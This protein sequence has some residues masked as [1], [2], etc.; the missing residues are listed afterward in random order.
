M[1]KQLE[2]EPIQPTAD[3]A[4][5]NRKAD[6]D[7]GGDSAAEDDV[8]TKKRLRATRVLADR[9]PCLYAHW[10]DVRRA[11]TLRDGSLADEFA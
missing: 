6:G 10:K 8:E 2:L 7:G 5:N 9:L 1:P 11:R 3:D 4:D